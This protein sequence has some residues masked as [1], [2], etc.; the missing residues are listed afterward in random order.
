GEG[1]VKWKCRNCG[2]DFEARSPHIDFGSGERVDPKCPSC[3]SY[4]VKPIIE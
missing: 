1:M 3:E 4:A 2:T